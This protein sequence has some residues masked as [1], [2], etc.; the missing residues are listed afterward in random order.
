G[1]PPAVAVDGAALEVGEAGGAYL[2]IPAFAVGRRCGGEEEP[3]LAVVGAAV[4]AENDAAAP[5]GA[6]Q[7]LLGELEAGL[8]GPSAG[9]RGA[10]V[11]A[12]L[13]AAA[14]GEPPG[15]AGAARVVAVE[16]QHPALGVD[17]HDPGGGAG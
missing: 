1:G 7:F 2:D 6:E 10:Q 17:Q 9:G 15:F 14:D 8:L 16:Q 3:F 5:Q 13:D 12:G 4:E 11:L